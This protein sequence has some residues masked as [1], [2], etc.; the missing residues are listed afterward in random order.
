MMMTRVKK[1]ENI[2]CPETRKRVF[3]DVFV[4]EMDL[5]I[6]FTKTIVSAVTIKDN[7]MHCDKIIPD[8]TFLIFKKKVPPCQY[9]QVCLQE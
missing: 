9:F 7:S 6:L 4:V 1:Y 2:F 8:F 5:I 3:Q